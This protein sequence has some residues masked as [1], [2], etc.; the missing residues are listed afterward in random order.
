MT[1][2][3]AL[4]MPEQIELQKSILEM[5]QVIR[6]LED[7]LFNLQCEMRGMDSQWDSEE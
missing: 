4:S 3:K 1:T 2:Y 6:E 5:E 7:E